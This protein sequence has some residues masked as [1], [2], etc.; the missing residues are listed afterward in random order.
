M[1]GFDESIVREYFE[2]NGFLVRQIRKYQVQAR[3]KQAREE[4]DLLVYNPAYTA[5]TRAAD[6]VL[7]AGELAC[8]HRAVVSVKGWHSAQRISPAMLSN[9]PAL[10]KFLQSQVLR[11]AEDYF[12]EAEVAFQSPRGLQKIL[13]LPG[14]PPHDPQR[15]TC[16]RLLREKGVDGILTFTSILRDLIAQVHPNLNYQK[17]EMMQVLRLLKNYDFIKDPQTELFA[18]KSKKR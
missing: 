10:F 13:V 2:A 9:S 6:F 18:D 5:S 8:L 16:L 4:I 1:A 11:T 7:D 17:S 15:S 3:K 12:A 14:L